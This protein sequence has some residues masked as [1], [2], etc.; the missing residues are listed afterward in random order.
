VEAAATTTAATTPTATTTTTRTGS[1]RGFRAVW[2][3]Q[4]PLEILQAGGR[5]VDEARKLV[6]KARKV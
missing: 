2:V 4:Q 5:P 1:A 3:V 6:V